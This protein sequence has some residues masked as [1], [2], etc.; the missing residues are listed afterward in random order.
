MDD[1][2]Q[3]DDLEV[4]DPQEDYE[5]SPPV[6]KASGRRRNK[7]KQRAIEVS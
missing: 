2:P 7:G 1:P 5:E 3:A 6:K 4:S